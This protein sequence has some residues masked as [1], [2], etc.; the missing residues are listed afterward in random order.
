[1][2]S[3][4][5]DCPKAESMQAHESRRAQPDATPASGEPVRDRLSG[6]TASDSDD[7]GSSSGPTFLDAC[8]LILDVVGRTSFDVIRYS[9][10]GS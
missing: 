4:K 3:T 7:R 2:V 5:E 9:P 1:M 8:S 10:L 6:A